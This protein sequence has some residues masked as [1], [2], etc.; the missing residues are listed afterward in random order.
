MRINV[1]KCLF[2]RDGCAVSLLLQEWMKR[3]KQQQKQIKA[4]SMFVEKRFLLNTQ[5]SQF[6]QLDSFAVP[7]LILLTLTYTESQF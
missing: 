3:S 4:T 6:S 1:R 2:C 5:V 7:Y